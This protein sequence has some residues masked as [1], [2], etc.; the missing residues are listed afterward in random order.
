MSHSSN[1]TRKLPAAYPL[2]ETS[3]REYF[4]N[5]IQK[6]SSALGRRYCHFLPL[7]GWGN[8]LNLA[9]LLFF[10][11]VQGQT[12][13]QYSFR[14]LSITW[15]MQYALG[16]LP[17]IFM[18]VYRI[19]YLKE[20]SVWQVSP[21]LPALDSPSY[22][23]CPTGGFWQPSHAPCLQTHVACWQKQ[24]LMIKIMGPPCAS[25]VTGNTIP[26][27]NPSDR[28]CSCPL[29]SAVLGDA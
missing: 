15:R 6:F 8:I 9:V 26:P 11:G 1:T 20:S 18:L 12:G 10:L 2:F 21:P 13:P 24:G 19:F 4:R 7:Q 23:W 27:P 28:L 17:I 16:L 3:T 5:L 29:G 14:A 25:G 22:M